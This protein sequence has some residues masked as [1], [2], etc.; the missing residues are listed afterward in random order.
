MSILSQAAITGDDLKGG[1]SRQGSD[2][3]AAARPGHGNQSLRL[4]I[5][6]VLLLE[7]VVLLNASYGPLQVVAG[8]LTLGGLPITALVTRIRWEAV[9]LPARVVYSLT[10]TVLGCLLVG[11]AVNT[12]LPLVGIERP[13][14]RPCLV[15]TSTVVNLGLVWWCRDV[16]LLRR[17]PRPKA[18]VRALFDL[19]FEPV[20]TVATMSVLCSVVGAV[21]LNNG[22][23]SVVAVVA[24]TLVGVGFALMLVRDTAI[25]RDA[26]A[27]FLLSSALLLATSLRGWFITGHDIQREYLVYLLTAQ[28]DHWQMSSFPD[29]YNACLSINILPTILST[30]SGLSGVVV[31]KLVMQLLFAAVPVMVYLASARVVPRRLAVLAVVFFTAFPTF[32]SDMP[33][34]V[35]QEV[36]FLFLAACL[37]AATEPSWSVRARRVAVTV[38]GV[39]VVLSHYATT[40]VLLAGLGLGLAALLVAAVGGRLRRLAGGH[41]LPDRMDLRLLSTLTLLSPLVIAALAAATWAWTVP[42]THSGGHV[43]D[44][45]KGSIS[46]LLYGSD[47]PG[48]SDLAYGILHRDSLTAQQRLDRYAASTPTTTGSPGTSLLSDAEARHLRP[49][50]AEQA[51]LPLT[52]AGTLLSSVGIGVHEVNSLL[53]TVAALLMQLF[54]LVGVIAVWLRSKAAQRFSREARWLVM[55]SLGALALQVLVPNLSVEYGVLRAFQQI[56]VVAAPVVALGAVLMLRPLGRWAVRVAGV[57]ALGLYFSLSG[58]IPAALGGY[59]AQLALSN[60]G[61][62]YDLYYVTDPEVAAVTWLRHAASGKDVQ[63]EVISDRYTV[64]RLKSY[65]NASTPTNDEFFP[66]QL[67]TGNY[68]FVGR[69]T[70]RK[71]VATVSYAGD[72]LSYYYPI[73]LL[74]QRMD[75]IY[76]NGSAEVYR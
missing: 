5:V 59:P 40:Y 65:L 73:G 61:Q 37:L 36:A 63:S 26:A 12:V 27:V 34:L 49:R 39:G 69:A 29:P 30:F 4:I 76:S 43:A 15:I 51:Q 68:V 31:F 38:F 11:L 28:P 3:P 41:P 55:G 7:L 16:P 70:V 21:R 23:G 66:T 62:Y 17:L 18:L 64:R 9:P 1:V 8:F 13:L 71:G 45:F 20:L 75:L 24:L 57:V 60:S 58:V 46:E 67:R 6:T 14:A 48:S 10:A 22:A 42:A 52:P 25:A 74:R 33:F 2:R 72:L 50:I 19:R 54:L 35:R 53:R 56:L 32:F 44:T 47:Q